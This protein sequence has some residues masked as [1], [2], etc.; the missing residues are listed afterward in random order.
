MKS[1]EFGDFWDEILGIW[2]FL[3]LNL[4]NLKILGF[5]LW[6][7][8]IFGTK[9]SEFGDF[10][11]EIL[12]IPGGFFGIIPPFPSGI[13]IALRGG[14]GGSGIFGNSGNSGNSG[15]WGGL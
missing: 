15:I 7:L 9:S 13:P 12:G 11:G 3:G 2:G 8:G 14:G 6:N 4:W 10:W 1:S 5:S